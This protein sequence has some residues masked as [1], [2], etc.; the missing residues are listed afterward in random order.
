MSE[1]A[2]A[3][4]AGALP[5]GLRSAYIAAMA[6]A[7][8]AESDAERQKPRVRDAFR[9]WRTASVALQ[10]F[11]SGLPLGLVFTA[12]P[13]WLNVQGIDVK[14]IGFVAYAQLPWAFKFVWAPVMDRYAPPF[15]G[16]KRGWAVVAQVG[17][18][19]G[20]LWLAFLAGGTVHLG[21]VAAATFVVA[22]FSASQDIAIDAYAVE[23]LRKD[24][25]G[26]AAGARSALSRLALFLSGRLV[27]SASAA[28]SWRV[29]FALQGLVYAPAMLLMAC[30]P[31]PEEAGRPPV[32]LR[33]AVWAP[34][35]D[36]LRQHNALQI[37][38]F[39]V[40]YK[41]GD[42]LAS[43]LVSVF[44]AQT[45]F[46]EWDIGVA[47]G[48]IGMIGTI[49]GGLIGGTITTALGLGHSLWL[50]GLLQAFSNFGYVF[51]AEVGP[52][53][54]VMYGAIAVETITSG[55][56]TGA[57]SV[58]L[59]RLTQKQFSASQYALLSSV[60]ALGRTLA[61]PMAGVLVDALGWSTFFLLT[62][63][64]AAPGLIMLQMFVP[65]GTQEP[66]LRQPIR[67]PGAP[68][69]VRQLFA[70]AVFG[71]GVALVAGAAISALLDTL[72]RMRMNGWRGGD[73][74]DLYAESVTALLAPVTAIDWIGLASLVT[75]AAV[76]GLGAAA[77]PAARRG[78]R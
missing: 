65:F 5:A 4:A 61:Q 68:L 77:L 11:P 25:Q 3:R 78:T 46:G 52:S 15:L 62:I 26:V 40:L 71:F 66:V 27:I 70:R 49:L 69:A 39:L 10:S 17:L 59:L 54:A 72:R 75:F 30:S 6:G 44:L 36:Y 55:M 37:T 63:G 41:F 48:T 56:G 38:A 67:A 34:F 13:Y 8:R 20:M 2:Q 51:I 12:I 19:L 43:A 31:E 7:G 57:F 47:Q 45:G 60:F 42:N 14:T 76:C 28:L 16:R 33:E 73:W 1:A 23:V 18:F 21:W 64:A 53:R 24:E 22:F 35:V 50:F 74:G 58:L 29:L 32:S 9:S